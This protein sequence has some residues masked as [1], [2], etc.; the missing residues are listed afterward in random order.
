MSRCVRA[1][2]EAKEQT[3]RADASHARAVAAGA[4]LAYDFLF[5]TT[6]RRVNSSLRIGGSHGRSVATDASSSGGAEGAAG[7]VPN[8]I[9]AAAWQ[10][11]DAA[12]LAWLDGGGRVDAT[13]T[14]DGLTG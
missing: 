7:S 4:I 14:R 3:S 12:V 10:S 6:L 2:A 8:E 5:C 1:P 13:F 11:D 9:V